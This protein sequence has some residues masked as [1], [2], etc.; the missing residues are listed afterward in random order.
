M[1][2]PINCFILF[3]NLIFLPLTLVVSSLNKY[4]NLIYLIYEDRI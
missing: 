1:E 3:I 2:I 4:I